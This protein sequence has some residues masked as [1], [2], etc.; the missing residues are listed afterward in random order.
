MSGKVEIDYSAQMLAELQEIKALLQKVEELL[1][2]RT[3]TNGRV[4]P[5][6]KPIPEEKDVS[7]VEEED[8]LKAEVVKT[9]ES[10]DK[11]VAG[12]INSVRRFPSG[13]LIVG[14][15]KGLEADEYKALLAAMKKA[16]GDRAY[17]SRKYHAFIIKKEENNRE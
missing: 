12:F 11:S 7:K 16:F 5:A 3:A 2:E 9:V 13:D 17:Y 15:R 14:F 8:V 1:E 10:H 4:V 6:R